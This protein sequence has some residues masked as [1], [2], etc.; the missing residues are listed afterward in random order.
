[1]SAE[2]TP[3][4]ISTAS[5]EHYTWGQNCDAWYFLKRDDIHII[6]ERMPP[7]AAEAMH[8]HWKSRQLFYVLS[9]ELTMK[10]ES[11]TLQ[12][13]RGQAIAIEP[14]S[15]HQASNETNSPVEF[16]VISCPPSHTDRINLD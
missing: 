9:G 13:P 2:K 14:N 11:A 10:L 16:L 5:A 8:Y 7:G 1:M 6:Q 4:P 12:I 15:P 3:Q